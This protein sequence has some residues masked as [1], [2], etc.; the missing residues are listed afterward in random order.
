MARPEHGLPK[1]LQL[2]AVLA[3][4]AV[5]V[6]G[7]AF[8]QQDPQMGGRPRHYPT[9][10]F[11]LFVAM[12]TIHTSA[13]KA[14]TEMTDYWREIQQAARA[15]YP[16]DP[17]KWARDEPVHR[18]HWQYMKFLIKKD[19]AA[20]EAILDAFESTAAQLAAEA[21]VCDPA[22]VGSLSRPGLARIIVG[23]GKVITPLYKAKK[24]MRRV[25]RETGEILG[26]KKYDPDAKMHTTGGGHPV[27]GNKFVILASR[28]EGWHSRWIH[29]LDHVPTAGG[30][31]KV[32]MA[33]LERTAPKLPGAQAVLY[34][35]AMRGKHHRQTLRRLGVQMISPPAAARAETKEG[36]RESKTTFIETVPHPDDPD[37]LLSI[38]AVDGALGVTDYDAD[39]EP[40][41]TPL[42]RLKTYK[43][44]NA[45]GTWRWYC[46]YALPASLGGGKVTIR[47]DT[48]DED[49]ARGVNRSENL[50]IVPPAD[51]DYDRIYPLRSDIE[52]CNRQLDD[53]LWLRR[54]HSVGAPAQLLDLVGYA[55][56][57][58]S[59]ALYLARQ[60]ANAPPGQA[61]AA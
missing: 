3:N 55:L 47:M 53:T 28:H 30:E 36:P 22:D 13:R 38:Y 43:R 27:Y 16:D 52:A 56:V 4:E 12:I 17:T 61:T 2:R 31:A 39:G 34:D 21:G 42:R 60:Q 54:A 45:D 10:V 37:R 48:T 33:A 41:F 5:W 46:D 19:P 7:E 40:H 50:R 24:G 51:P 9:W 14:A 11:A 23:D 1:G 35:G 20:L 57:Y 26:D 59:V 18:R 32:A 29:G 6:I 44:R 25:D 49:L 15:R 8:P 58:N